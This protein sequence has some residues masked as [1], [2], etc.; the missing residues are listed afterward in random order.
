MYDSMIKGIEGFPVWLVVFFFCSIY[1]FIVFDTYAIFR[2]L[3]SK[4]E[5]VVIVILSSP[6]IL[7]FFLNLFAIRK[8]RSGYDKLTSNT[9]IDLFTWLVLVSLLVLILCLR[10]KPKV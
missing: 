7:R 10:L 9:T 4:W 1:G 2:E 5:K 6:F 3:R 8:T